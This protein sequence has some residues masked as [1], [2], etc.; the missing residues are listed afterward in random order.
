MRCCETQQHTFAPLVSQSAHGNK[1]TWPAMQALALHTASAPQARATETRTS[2]ASPGNSAG[3]QDA[4]KP[5]ALASEQHQP[6]HP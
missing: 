4:G 6:S 1:Q 3:L 5:G 2:P